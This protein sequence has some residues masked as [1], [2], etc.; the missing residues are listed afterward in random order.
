MS[1]LPLTFEGL[2]LHTGFRMD[3]VVDRQVVVEV[4]ALERVLPVHGAQLLTYL[5]FSG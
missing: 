2:E 3:L 1:S 5:R 4:K